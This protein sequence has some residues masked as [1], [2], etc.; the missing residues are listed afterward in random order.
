MTAT[1]KDYFS[2]HAA[3]YARYRPT[4]PPA[5]FEYCAQLPARRDLALDCATGNGQAALALAERFARVVGTDASAQQVAAAPRADR[6]PRNALFAVAPAER[7]PLADRSADLVMVAQALHWLNHGAF[8]GEVERV[9]APGGALVATMYDFLEGGPEIDAAVLALRHHVDS[10][11]PPE[12]A[13]TTAEGFA[14]LPFLRREESPP[15]ITMLRDWT[16]A[17]LLG[18]LSTWSAVRRYMAKRNSDPIAE[19]E[20]LFAAAWGDPD[21]RRPIRWPLMVR[22]GRVA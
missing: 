12:R 17:E 6:R 7:A 18:Y 20:P 3:D 9:L 1:F 5:L 2:G 10:F 8:Y 21:V 19:V 4:Y 13:G 14:A 15:S 22:V 11:W 16:L